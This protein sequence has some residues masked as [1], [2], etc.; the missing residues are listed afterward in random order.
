VPMDDEHTLFFNMSIAGR[1]AGGTPSP[2]PA[3]W[4]FSGME[5]RAPSSDWYGRHRLVSSAENDYRIDRGVQRRK[6]DYT[7]IAGIHTQDQA[8]T[9]SMGPIYDRSQERLGSSDAMIIR[10]RRRLM[11]AARELAETGR[12]PL[13]VEHPEVYRQRSGGVICR[14]M[15]TGSPRPASCGRPTSSTPSWTRRWPA[16]G[17]SAPIV[18]RAFTWPAADCPPAMRSS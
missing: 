8:V 18:E 2:G 13:S 14:G 11:D 5:Q 9:E 7:G 1:T 12:A 6:D 3:R 15:W 4:T 17:D 16:A 10:V